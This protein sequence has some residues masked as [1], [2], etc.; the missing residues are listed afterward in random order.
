[1]LFKSVNIF[2]NLK[3]SY[4]TSYMSR[5]PKQSSLLNK[6]F[7]RK[8]RTSCDVNKWRRVEE[9]RD[10]EVAESGRLVSKVN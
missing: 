4:I 6:I 1:M 3:L 2:H 8:L 5:K 9:G 10:R 7:V